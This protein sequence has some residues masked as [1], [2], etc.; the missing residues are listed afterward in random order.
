M[1]VSARTPAI[2]IEQCPLDQQR[3]CTNLPS[4]KIV[5]TLAVSS[6]QLIAL[7]SMNGMEPSTRYCV[8]QGKNGCTPRF[9]ASCCTSQTKLNKLKLPELSG[10]VDCVPMEN[11]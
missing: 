1:L 9:E 8:P 11:K 10:L 4:S 5:K 3:C 7:A 2:P 6:N